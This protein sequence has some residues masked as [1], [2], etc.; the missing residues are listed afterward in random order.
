MRARA[1]AAVA[2]AGLLLLATPS[3]GEGEGTLE[4]SASYSS[5]GSGQSTTAQEG[6]LRVARGVG[7]TV[8]SAALAFRGEGRSAVLELPVRSAVGTPELIA[9][10]TAG[11]A[12]TAGPDQP[13][14]AAPVADCERSTAFGTVSDDGTTVAFP[15]DGGFQVEPGLWSLALVPEP[16]AVQVLPPPSVPLPF[17]VELGAP[18]PGALL[19]SQETPLEPAAPV[20]D[21][22]APAP[23]AEPAPTASSDLPALLAG[24]GTADLPATAPLAAAP[25]PQLDDAVEPPVAAAAPST[26]ARARPVAASPVADGVDRAQLLVVAALMGVAAWLGR[27]SAKPQAALRLLGGRARLAGGPVEAAAVVPS[28]G[29]RPRGLGRFARPR[30]AAPRSLR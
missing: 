6:D 18:G 13:L 3:W 2:G 14:S 19:L 22:A 30:D 11:T 15:L 25:L 1:A 9:C 5:A 28:R 12:W 20:E 21:P 4:R 26:T 24:T 23:P 7:S 8:A 17:S 27:E 16:G 29:E 10:P